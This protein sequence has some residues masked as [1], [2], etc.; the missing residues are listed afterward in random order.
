VVSSPALADERLE[1]REIGPAPSRKNVS[2]AASNS[3][4]AASSS[5]LAQAV[6]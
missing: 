1:P 3:S 5:E 4:A 6:R 2:R